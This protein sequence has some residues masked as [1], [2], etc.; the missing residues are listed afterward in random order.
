[1]PLILILPGVRRKALPLSPA[2][3]L[4][5]PRIN[6]E[7]RIMAAPTDPAASD[8]KPHVRDYGKFVA[9]FKWGTIISAILTAIVVFLIAD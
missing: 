3:L 2:A 7:P 4:R 8:M 1:M 6:T 5:R 9:M